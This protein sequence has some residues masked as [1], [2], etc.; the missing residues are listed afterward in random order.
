MKNF[1]CLV[2]L[3]VTAAYFSPTM[4]MAL[5]MAFNIV[6]N[7]WTSSSAGPL[8]VI[9]VPVVL[10]LAAMLLYEPG[11]YGLSNPAKYRYYHVWTEENGVSV[12]MKFEQV[13]QHSPET[14][15]CMMHG[16][17]SN[18]GAWHPLKDYTE[19]GIPRKGAQGRPPLRHPDLWST[20]TA[21]PM[22]PDF[23]E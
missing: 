8:L 3:L 1:G 10:L 18:P 4:L 2:V 22:P 16:G 12:P 6:H 19:R 15:V 9:G 5:G 14:L 13:K 7:I 17:A 20:F 23:S 11:S 21:G